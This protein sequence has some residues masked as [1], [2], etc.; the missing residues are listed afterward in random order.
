MNLANAQQIPDQLEE[1]PGFAVPEKL[2]K[3][4]AE[5]LTHYPQKRSATLMVLHLFQQEFGFVSRQAVEWTAAR[6]ELQPINIYEL[7]TFYPMFHRKP[8]GK[9]HVRVCRTLSCALAGAYKVHD[10]FCQRL[11]LD[12]E[13]HGPQTTPDGKVT[14]E[15]VECLAGCDKAPVVLCNDVFHEEVTQEKAAVILNKA[16]A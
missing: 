1:Q 3:E 8:S 15:F 7:V 10:F 9:T 5:L 11:G 2:E 14:V 13:I 12:P 6:L 4:V 16:M